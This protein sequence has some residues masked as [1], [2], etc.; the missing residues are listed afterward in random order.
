[1][2]CVAVVPFPTP[3]ENTCFLVLGGMTFTLVRVIFTSHYQN[4]ESNYV[5]NRNAVKWGALYDRKVCEKYTSSGV[6][7]SIAKMGHLLQ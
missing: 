7:V 4:T 3:C 2:F 1:M 6:K 5:T